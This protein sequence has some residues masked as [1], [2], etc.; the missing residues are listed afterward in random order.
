MK[1]KV[2]ARQQTEISAMI[3][4]IT[5][6]LAIFISLIIA[7]LV[8]NFSAN[9]AESND[10]GK[11][12]VQVVPSQGTQEGKIIVDIQNNPQPSTK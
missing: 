4:A 2:I 3:V 1:K 5:I 10:S 8:L 6:I 9:S 12:I 7:F 11:V